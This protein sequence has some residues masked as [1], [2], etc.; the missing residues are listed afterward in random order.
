MQFDSLNNEPK[1]YKE[2]MD[3]LMG[4]GNQAYALRWNHTFSPRLFS[5]L[6]LNYSKF[7][8]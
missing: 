8:F 7:L 6:T 2:Q 3:F 5:N 1:R 4:W